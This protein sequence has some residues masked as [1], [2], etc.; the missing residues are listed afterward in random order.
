MANGMQRI[1]LYTTIY[2]GAEAY[3]GHWHRSVQA[4]TDKGFQLCIGLDGIEREVVESMIGRHLEAVWAPSSLESTPARVRQESL[5]GIVE[6]FDAVVLVDC[7]DVLHPARVAAAR[8]ALKTSELAACALRL[9]S[10]QGED[11]GITLT[12]P[13]RGKPDDI[14]PRNNIFGFSNSAYRSGLLARCLPIPARVELVD[15]FLATRAWLMGASLAFDPVVRM[16]YRQHSANTAPIRFPFEAS[17]VIRNAL[18][19]RRH[20]ESLLASP[21]K[22]ALPDRWARVQK[23]SEDVR[24]FTEEVVAQPCKLETYLGKLNA[25]KPQAIWWWD[26][27]HPALQWMWRD[28]VEMR[29]ETCKN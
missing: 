21:M 13:E 22:N 18:K 25:L 20:F 1:A 24:L 9:T 11:L 12:L 3:L 5:A 28:K 4:Q 2:P 26:V 19:V 17:Q 7:D 8:M 27:A 14:L 10:Q 6:R 15:W 16:D 23:V 29:Y